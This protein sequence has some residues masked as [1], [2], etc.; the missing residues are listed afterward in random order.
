[1]KILKIALGI[2]LLGASF[3]AFI[4][5]SNSATSFAEY[6]PTF[7]LVIISIFLLRSGINSKK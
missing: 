6:I 5:L 2:I 1:M 4:R 3:F 7:V